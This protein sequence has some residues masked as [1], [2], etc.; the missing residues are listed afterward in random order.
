MKLSKCIFLHYSF[1]LIIRRSINDTKSSL[2]FCTSSVSFWNRRSWNFFFHR[3]ANANSGDHLVHNGAIPRYFFKKC[4][5]SHPH[6]VYY[7]PVLHSYLYFHPQIGKGSI[8]LYYP[9]TK[10]IK[11]KLKFVVLNETVKTKNMFN[12]L[13]VFCAI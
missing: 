12:L 2:S 8:I 1:L 3:P 5:S 11:G 9:K 13:L 6:R 7:L 4:I 10:F